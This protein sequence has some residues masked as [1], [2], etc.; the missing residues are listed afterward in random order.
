MSKYPAEIEQQMANAMRYMKREIAKALILP[1]AMLVIVGAA[2]AI[3]WH[4]GMVPQ[5]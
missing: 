3:A 5:L 2:L 1:S 4:H